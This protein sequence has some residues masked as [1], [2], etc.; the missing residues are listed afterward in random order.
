MIRW[1]AKLLVYFFLWTSIGPAAMAA[2]APP[3]HACCVRKK[4]NQHHHHEG[5]AQREDTV[6][7]THCEQGHRCC[8]PLTVSHWAQTRPAVSQL[9][10]TGAEIVRTIASTLYHPEPLASQAPARAPPSSL[11]S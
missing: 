4:L 9:V 5:M 11:F 1:T 3:A 2:S 8:S 6:S 10:A 7:S